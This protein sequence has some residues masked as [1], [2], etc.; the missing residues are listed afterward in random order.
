MRYV[1]TVCT[2]SD[3]AA[4]IILLYIFIRY[5]ATILESLRESDDQGLSLG[6][7]VFKRDIVSLMKLLLRELYI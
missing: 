7:L 1:V 3:G 4:N 5:F 6:Y 2:R